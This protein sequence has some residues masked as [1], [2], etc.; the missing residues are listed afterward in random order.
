MTRLSLAFVALVTFTT[1]ASAQQQYPLPTGNVSAP[2]Y[3]AIP[4]G[5]FGSTVVFPV[6]MPWGWGIGWGYQTYDPWVGY[7]YVYG[8]VLPSLPAIPTMPTQPTATAARRPAPVILLDEVF[9]AKLSLQFPADAEVWLNGK[10]ASKTPNKEQELT[11]PALRADQTYTFN[12]KAR[13][14]SK[15]KTYEATRTIAVKPGE[16]GRLMILSGEEVRD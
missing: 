11:S 8:G 16:H 14:T 3:A 6:I 7:R 9:P 12:V 5:Q 10:K 15:G 4:Q 13:W 1:V 2:P